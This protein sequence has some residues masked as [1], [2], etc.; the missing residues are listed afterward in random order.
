[1]KIYTDKGMVEYCRYDDNLTVRCFIEDK[2]NLHEDLDLCFECAV[3][4]GLI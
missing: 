1:M 2:T 4:E 3:W